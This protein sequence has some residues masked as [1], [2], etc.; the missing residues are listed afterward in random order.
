[1]KELLG[2]KNKN[3]FRRQLEQLRPSNPYGVPET[4]SAEDRDFFSI[5]AA[6]ALVPA[7]PEKAQALLNVYGLEA[8]KK[9]IMN[10]PEA[11]AKI[12]DRI[13]TNVLVDNIGRREVLNAFLNRAVD[14]GA[15]ADAMALIDALGKHEDR[16]LKCL[17]QQIRNQCVKKLQQQNEG[18]ADV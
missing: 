18:N 7:D 13:N 6:N 10:D 8:L 9:R 12:A 14:E 2:S 1:M 16:M 15:Q 17:G 5:G 11:L 4:L 3:P